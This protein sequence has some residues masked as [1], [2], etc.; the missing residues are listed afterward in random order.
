MNTKRYNVN[1]VPRQETLKRKTE[2]CY[3][4]IATYS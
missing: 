2:E 4:V 1:I 3:D